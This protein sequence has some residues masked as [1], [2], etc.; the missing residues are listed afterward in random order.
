MLLIFLACS[1]IEPEITAGDPTAPMDECNPGCFSVRMAEDGNVAANKKIVVRVEP[2]GPKPLE[3][4][5]ETDES[6]E[7]EICLPPGTLPVGVA[8]LTISMGIQKAEYPLDIRPFGYHVGR[9]RTAGAPESTSTPQVKL[10]ETPFLSNEKDTWYAYQISTPSYAHGLLAFAG[11]PRWEGGSGHNPYHIGVARLNAD[12]SIASISDAPVITPS[13]WDANTQHDPSLIWDGTQYI[14]Y[15]QG[16]PDGNADPSI[17]RAFSP[18]GETWTSDP[19]NPVYVNAA[20]HG[21]SHAMVLRQ[22]ETLSE[23]WHA[24][25]GGMGYALSVDEGATWEGYCANP[26]FPAQEDGSVKTPEVSW[27]GEHYRMAFAVGADEIW[28]IGWAESYDGIRWT[29]GEDMLEPGTHGW[30]NEDLSNAS[31][32]DGP[33]GP[34]WMLGAVG[35]ESSAVVLAEAR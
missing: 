19:N 26:V 7:T 24:G 34:T 30:D 20:E 1:A 10:P 32:V 3:L 27:D 6:G 31:L 22:D 5:L 15:Y 35:T 25:L 13:D 2:A 21:A 12:W 33:N 17:G 4:E 8:T 23:M 9:E 11:S 28:R 16:K 29:R 18:D 14:L